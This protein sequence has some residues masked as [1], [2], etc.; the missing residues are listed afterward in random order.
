M[1]IRRA[2]AKIAE[3]NGEKEKDWLRKVKLTMPSPVVHHIR[4]KRGTAWTIDSGY[5]N[6]AAY[7]ADLTTAYRKELRALHN[8]GCRYV[9]IDDPDLTYFCD[10]SFLSAL[11]N[12]GIDPD[13]LLSTY[14]QA[15]SD[16]IRDR[17]EGRTMG[18][19]LCRGNF[20]DDLWLTKGG[21][22]NIARRSITET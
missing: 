10:E 2:I 1:Q 7:F 12:D 3:G 8:A 6:D 21:Y 13:E 22:E 20:S 18:I 19:H 11:K 17:P 16:A 9:Q 14:L 5:N 4:L 15:H